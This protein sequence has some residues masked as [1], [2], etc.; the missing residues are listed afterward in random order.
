MTCPLNEV[1][2]AVLNVLLHLKDWR[3]P[4]RPGCVG[5]LW[6]PLH[7]RGGG[8]LAV[9]LALVMH[10]NTQSH[11]KK[12]GRKSNV[13]IIH[14]GSEK[15]SSRPISGSS[16]AAVTL[17]SLI[18]GGCL[19][20][21]LELAAEWLRVTCLPG[22]SRNKFSGKSVRNVFGYAPVDVRWFHIRFPLQSKWPQSPQ[23][24]CV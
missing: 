22:N 11:L 14:R 1:H 15:R 17:P 3:F 19:G 23:T 21:S 7:I 6:A 5:S 20:C 9:W 10:F 18:H 2:L 12:G 8:R 4:L 13:W 16:V 24:P